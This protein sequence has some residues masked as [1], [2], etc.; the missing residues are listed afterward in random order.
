MVKK[1]LSSSSAW[2]S[3]SAAL[4]LLAAFVWLQGTAINNSGFLLMTFCSFL[5]VSAGTFLTLRTFA[6][7]HMAMT[8]SSTHLISE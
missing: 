6:C 8:V 3:L 2:S 1:D 4:L 5:F 7:M